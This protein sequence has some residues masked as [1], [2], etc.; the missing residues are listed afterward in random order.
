[1]EIVEV[2]EVTDELVAAMERLVPQLAPSAP[3]PTRAHLEALVRSEACTL[4]VARD[5]GIVGT[6]TLARYP[7]PSGVRVHVEDVVVDEAGR[8]KGVGEALVRAALARARELGA[9]SVDL[10]SRPEREAANRLYLRLGFTLRRTNAYRYL[11]E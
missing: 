3:G 9:R 2:T 1:M 4:M 11:F 7:I 10:T 8:G 5:G 6:L